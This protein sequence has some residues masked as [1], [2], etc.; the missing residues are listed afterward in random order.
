MSPETAMLMHKY[1]L[2]SIPDVLLDFIPSFVAAV[3]LRMNEQ[4]RN[5]SIASPIKKL[6]NQLVEC[7]SLNEDLTQKVAFFEVIFAT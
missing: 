4:G 1:A 7:Q 5:Q 2:N 3:L 6:Q